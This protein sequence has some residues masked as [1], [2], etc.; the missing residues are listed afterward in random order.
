MARTRRGVGALAP[1]GVVR[2]GVGAV[3]AR[4]GRPRS[5]S[6]ARRRAFS[7]SMRVPLV[8][9]FTPDLLLDGVLDELE[10]VGPQH[11]LAA[12]DVHVEH[13]HLVRARR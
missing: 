3:D 1:D 11:R 6:P 12:T 10:E 9:N 4:S 2:R 13:L 7:A 8:E 5:P